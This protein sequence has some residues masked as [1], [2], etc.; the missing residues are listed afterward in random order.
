MVVKIC[1]S[2]VLYLASISLAT[3]CFA[4]TSSRYRGKLVNF[5]K[6]CWHHFRGPPKKKGTGTMAGPPLALAF[7]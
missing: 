7:L 5:N 6:G 1:R 2:V 3:S 4:Q